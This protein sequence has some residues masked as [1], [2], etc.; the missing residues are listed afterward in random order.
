VT[1]LAAVYTGIAFIAAQEFINVGA[2]LD[3]LFDFRP[4]AT[5]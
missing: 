5:E 1:V 2:R 4:R 3:Q